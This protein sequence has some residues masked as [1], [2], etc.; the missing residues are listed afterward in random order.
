MCANSYTNL[1]CTDDADG[2]NAVDQLWTKLLNEY[3][4]NKSNL[5]NYADFT[6]FCRDVLGD[7]ATE[8]L[9]DSFR[10]RGDF[11]G[12][13]AHAYMEFLEQD[14]NLAGPVFYL[15][16]GMPQFPKRMISRATTDHRA[17]LYLKEKVFRI[18]DARASA[19]DYA[20]LIETSRYRIHAK[21]VVAAMDPSGWKNIH[22]SIAHDIKFNRHFQ[23]ILP[24]KTV[25]IQ[26]YWP[27]RWWEDSSS[28]VQTSIVCG[29][30]KTVSISLKSALDI[31]KNETRA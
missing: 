7:E 22:G 11:E 17:R 12:T 2:L 31:R 4:H 16:Q 24:V 29:L 1:T 20:F 14:W 3:R 21:Q 15:R 13:N 19:S 27:R 25:T 6:A 9:R 26:C 10:F 5:Y 28:F 18:D 30:D 8:Y 23:A